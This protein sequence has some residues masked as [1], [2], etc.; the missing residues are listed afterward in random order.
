MGVGVILLLDFVFVDDYD[1]VSCFYVEWFLD[2]WW[3]VSDI[4]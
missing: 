4:G 2:V 3:I 1:E